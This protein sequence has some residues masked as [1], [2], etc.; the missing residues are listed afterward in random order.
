[1]D[2]RFERMK[3]HYER[4]VERRHRRDISRS[5]MCLLKDNHAFCSA[6]APNSEDDSSSGDS[7][8]GD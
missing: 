6:S 5:C 1:M 7:A 2:R 8:G 4:R 3:A